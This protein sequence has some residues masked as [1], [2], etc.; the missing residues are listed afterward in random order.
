[1]IRDEKI[2]RALSLHIYRARNIFS[3]LMMTLI[4]ENLDFGFYFVNSTRTVS[5]TFNYAAEGQHEQIIVTKNCAKHRGCESSRVTLPLVLI[6]LAT[7]IE[8]L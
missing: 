7:I 4:G 2:F 1:M 8:M 3:S 5:Y 6:K